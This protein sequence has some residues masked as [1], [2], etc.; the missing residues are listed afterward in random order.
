[1]ADNNN[2][3]EVVESLF[4]GMDSFVTAKTVVGEPVHI[5][6]TILLPLV[7][8]SFGVGAGAGMNGEKKSDVGGGGLGA[9]ISPSAVLVIRDGVT[10]LVNIKNQDTVTKVLDMV[11]DVIDRVVPNRKDPRKDPD[12][13]KA[14]Q[15]VVEEERGDTEKK[16]ETK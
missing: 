1:M 9:K 4:R 11:P 3:G 7:D 15:D 16:T 14:V 2:F 5:N 12:V 10:K 8:V 13:E 6:D